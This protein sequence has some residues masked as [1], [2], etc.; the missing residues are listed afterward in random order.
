MPGDETRQKTHD[1]SDSESELESEL[2][3]DVSESV[4]ESVSDVSEVACCT[5][6]VVLG[7]LLFAVFWGI[8]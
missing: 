5:G 7:M 8:G 6:L 4:S 2:E 3:V 1:E